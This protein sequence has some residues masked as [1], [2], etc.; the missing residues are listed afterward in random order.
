[1]RRYRVEFLDPVEG[2]VQL[3]GVFDSQQQAERELRDEWERWQKLTLERG[4]CGVISILYGKNFEVR[5][6]SNKVIVY[7]IESELV[8]STSGLHGQRVAVPAPSPS[9][10]RTRRRVRGH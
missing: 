10:G 3:I 9:H 4:F 5:T 8:P 7:R 1:M 2:D 6:P